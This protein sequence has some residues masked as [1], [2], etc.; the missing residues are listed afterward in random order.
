MNPRTYFR[1]ALLIPIIFPYGV[2][3]IS[4][5]SSIPALLALSI[6]FGGFG[7][8]TLAVIQWLR[9]GTLQNTNQY[10]RL[11]FTTPLIFIPIY[12]IS[13]LLW[14]LIDPS[15]QLTLQST[16]GPLAIFS[17]YILLIGYSYALIIY[18][19]FK[20]LD[21]SGFFAKYANNSVK[22]ILQNLPRCLVVVSRPWHAYRP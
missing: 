9:L 7:Y 12:S 1:L 10:V 18:I 21:F 13:W 5:H 22:E 6:G 3:A 17:A 15:G 2:I 4:S 11:S 20:I 19:G 8:V 14:C 16:L